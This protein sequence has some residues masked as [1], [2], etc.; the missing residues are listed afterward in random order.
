MPVALVATLLVLPALYVIA[1]GAEAARYPEHTATKLSH[2]MPA[3]EEAL[4]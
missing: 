3:Q 4:R 1:H 2:D